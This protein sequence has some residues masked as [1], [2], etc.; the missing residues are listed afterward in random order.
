MEGLQAFVA[1]SF[2][3]RD[4]AFV[5]KSTSS[6]SS[7]SSTS[8]R[9]RPL[10][11]IQKC[12]AWLSLIGN[13]ACTLAA[14]SGSGSGQ[15]KGRTTS[16]AAAGLSTSEALA[17]FVPRS[18][19]GG[20]LGQGVLGCPSKLCSPRQGIALSDLATIRGHAGERADQCFKPQPL[21]ARKRH[22]DKMTDV[23]PSKRSKTVETEAENSHK[24]QQKHQTSSGEDNVAMAT[25]T[26]TKKD[27]EREFAHASVPANSLSP[28]LPKSGQ[29]PR[30]DPST[31]L[32]INRRSPNYISSLDDLSVP[33][34]VDVNDN[35]AV[36]LPGAVGDDVSPG[37]DSSTSLSG[38]E[39]IHASS[40]TQQCADMSAGVGG[41]SGVTASSAAGK[42]KQR[43]SRTN[44][45]AE[46]LSEL[47][48]LFDETHYPDAFM[49][50]ELSRKLGLSEARVQVWFQNRRAKC[51]KQEN[52][53]NKGTPVGSSASVDTCRVAPYLSMG[54]LRMPFERVQEQLQ[55]NIKPSPTSSSSPSASSPLSPPRALPVAA[56]AAAAAAASVPSASSLLAHT[57]S[58]MF[59][60]PPPYAFP[61][62]TLMGTMLARGAAV[63]S[64]SK[65]SSIA[66]LRLKAR[67]HAAALGLQAF[68]AP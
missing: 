3:G 46:Q 1:K 25:E 36:T 47:E 28:G 43:R 60:P 17:P 26:E 31:S 41:L 13:P 49:R 37:C 66:D 39:S 63:S 14:S 15:R 9:S 62:A 19:G 7:I 44:F 10:A 29:D 24:L 40:P 20:S 42:L 68:V 18:R 55:L 4:D 45:T 12:S 2:E 16:A 64:S 38:R 58:F 56:A 5:T 65:S 33:V 6:A 54:S 53:N 22:E 27:R 11:S 35:A 32:S 59:F 67:Q 51:R 50:E 30:S 23:P 48:K 21:T 57:P 34:V 8:A 52:H 61:L